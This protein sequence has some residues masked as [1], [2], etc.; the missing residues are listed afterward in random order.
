[1]DQKLRLQNL[2]AILQ[3]RDPKIKGLDARIERVKAELAQLG[4]NIPSQPLP[5]PKKKKIVTMEVE[6]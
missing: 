5:L 6:E 2:L 3:K 4:I 1:M